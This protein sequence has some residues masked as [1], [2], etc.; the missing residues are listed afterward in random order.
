MLG[1][2]K[3]E[4]SAKRAW[5][6]VGGHACNVPALKVLPKIHKPRLPNGDPK[7]RPVVGA[8]N[9]LNSRAG[10]LV[11]DV[12]EAV[13]RVGGGMEECIST[14]EVLNKLENT[15]KAV[16][17]LNTRVTAASADVTALYPALDIPLTAREVGKERARWSLG[18]WTLKQLSCMWHTM[19]SVITVL[20]LQ[21]VSK[22]FRIIQENII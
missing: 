9:A 7:T 14:E 21:C 12:I 4:E 22:K 17:D 20:I 3:G 2:D 19:H 16:K 5:S 10:D 15:A 1:E 13:I 8:A 6:N 18:T 11:A